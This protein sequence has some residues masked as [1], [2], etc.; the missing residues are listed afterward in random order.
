MTLCDLTHFR[1]DKSEDHNHF[2]TEAD[3]H[4]KNLK[5]TIDPGCGCS[6]IQRYEWKPDEWTNFTENKLQQQIQGY[7]MVS[8][9]WLDKSATRKICILTYK[10]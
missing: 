9:S 1:E 4:L 10:S 3:K 7:E 6:Y 2:E 8:D 5:L